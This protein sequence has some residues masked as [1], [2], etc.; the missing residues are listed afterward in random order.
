MAKVSANAL[1]TGGGLT[2]VQG[3]AA[4]AALVGA[5]SLFLLLAVLLAPGVLSLMADRSPGRP[6]SRASLLA[7]LALSV[8]PAWHLWLIGL[9]VDHALGLLADIG[10]LARAWSAGACGWLA[11]E[12]APFGVAALFEIQ[13]ER[14]KRRLIARRAELVGEWNLK[15]D[16]AS[17]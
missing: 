10:N 2:A 3:L 7:G 16:P 6:V 1:K 13:T 12:L 15:A 5:P 17:K 14:R 8:A 11:C 9:S 4:G